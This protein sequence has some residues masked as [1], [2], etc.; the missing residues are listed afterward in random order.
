MKLQYRLGWLKSGEQRTLIAIAENDMPT[1]K[2]LAS[3]LKCSLS[4]L[5]KYLPMLEKKGLI[6][7]RVDSKLA[8]TEMGL[9]CLKLEIDDLKKQVEMWQT[10]K[11]KAEHRYWVAR[12]T[13]GP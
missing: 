7:R 8:L 9:E 6:R 4:F 12:G 11:N 2:E 1:T 10:L 5:Y 3:T 13:Y